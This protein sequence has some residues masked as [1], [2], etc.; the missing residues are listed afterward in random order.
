[1]EIEL[2]REITLEDGTLAVEIDTFHLNKRGEKVYKEDK[3]YI[4]KIL[5]YPESYLYGR[6]VNS[7]IIEKN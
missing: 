4:E 7:I 3:K 5:Y 1:M 2:K 6:F